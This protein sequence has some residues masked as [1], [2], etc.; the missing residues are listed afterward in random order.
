MVDHPSSVSQF[1]ITST[2]DACDLPCPLPLL[3]AKQA[4]HQVD[5]GQCILVL[6]TDSGSV[7][8]FHAFIELS[9]HELLEYADNTT[10]YHYVIKKGVRTVE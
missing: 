2:V 10:H 9:E 1:T 7:R 4:L 5:G 8:D 3:K 6:A